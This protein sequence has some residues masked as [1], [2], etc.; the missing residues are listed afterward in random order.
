MH[1]TIFII[2]WVA[3]PTYSMCM[4][5]WC[6]HG[7]L[8]LVHSLCH[9]RFL[10]THGIHCE[11][12]KISKPY[13]VRSDVLKKHPPR[14]CLCNKVQAQLTCRCWTHCSTRTLRAMQSGRGNV[15]REQA[16]KIKVGRDNVSQLS[17]PSSELCSFSVRHTLMSKLLTAWSKKMKC[18][19]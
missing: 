2:L 10:C 14:E 3:S 11:V 17:W 7:L 16:F 18:G 6:E 4:G 15:L 1:C 13:T 8:V 5:W 12:H 9:I 19:I